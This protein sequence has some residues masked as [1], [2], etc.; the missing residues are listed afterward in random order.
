MTLGALRSLKPDEDVIEPTEAP[1]PGTP[2]AMPE[3][4]GMPPGVG[5]PGALPGLGPAPMGAGLPGMPPTPAGGLGAPPL[6]PTPPGGGI[7]P[8]GGPGV[9]R[10]RYRLGDWTSLNTWPHKRTG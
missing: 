8:P 1:L 2:G 3:E 10:L 6:G 9:D 4:A 5:M 7:S